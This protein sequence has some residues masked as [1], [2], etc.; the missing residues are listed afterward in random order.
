MLNLTVGKIG[1]VDQHNVFVVDQKHHAIPS[2]RHIQQLWNAKRAHQTFRL[3]FQ[4]TEIDLTQINFPLKT[5]AGVLKRRVCFPG[6]DDHNR[7]ALLPFL[8][9]RMYTVHGKLFELFPE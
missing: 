2:V 9:W 1:I 5:H 3:A 7:R 8:H 4:F 6:R